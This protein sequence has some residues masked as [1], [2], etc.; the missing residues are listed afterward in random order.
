MDLLLQKR[1]P[2]CGRHHIKENLVLTERDLKSDLIRAAD[3]PSL[4]SGLR[5]Q[6]TEGREHGLHPP[7][8]FLDL[9]LRLILGRIFLTQLLG[10]L[11]KQDLR[12]ERAQILLAPP[13]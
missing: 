3:E 1:L 11:D 2:F 4:E 9:L 12:P 6:R 8:Q 7:D 13:H 5:L 10:H